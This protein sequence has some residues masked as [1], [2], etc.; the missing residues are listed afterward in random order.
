VKIRVPRA[1]P[2]YGESFR[3]NVATIRSYLET[4]ENLHTFGRNGLHRYNNQDHSM[5][6]AILATLNLTA[7]TDY[8]VWSVNTEAE[9]LEEGD[10]VEAA[11]EGQLADVL[12]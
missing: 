10:A 9:Y 4:F 7:G 8:D 5:W 3:D 2:M 12:G 11:L 1:Y 6:T